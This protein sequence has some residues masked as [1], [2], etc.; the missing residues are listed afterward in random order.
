VVETC[1]VTIRH[2]VIEISVANKIVGQLVTKKFWSL[3]DLRNGNRI[4]LVNDCPH[5]PLAIEKIQ[6]P[7]DNIQKPHVVNKWECR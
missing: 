1:L 7:F 5:N 3:L 6:S 4:F 2:V